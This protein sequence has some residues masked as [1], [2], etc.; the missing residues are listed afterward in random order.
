MKHLI[1]LLLNLAAITAVL[2]NRHEMLTLS[3]SDHSLVRYTNDS[4]IVQCRSSTAESQLVWRSPKGEIIKEH[5]GRIHIV[6][7]APEQLKIVFLHIS[8]ADKGK[9]RCED[10][11]GDR[12]EKSFELIVYQKIAFT[13]NSTILTVKEGKDAFIRC[14][15]KGEPQPN[16]TWHY[17]GQP[18]IVESYTGNTTKF[19]I[20]ADGLQ[21]RKVTQNDTG[22][23][24]C[25]AYQ[26]NTIASDMQD[27]TILM[28]IEHKPIWRYS[29]HIPEQYVYPNG[30]VTIACE[31]IA[32]PPANFTWY[33]NGNKKRLHTDNRYTIEKDYYASTLTIRART[34]DVFDSYRCLAENQLGAIERST[35]LSR[36]VKP[37]PPSVLQLRGFNSNTFDVDV[38]S[39]RISPA[40]TP[41]TDQLMEVNGFR[42]EYMTEY[43]FKSDGGKWSNAKRRDFPF[44][45]GATFLINNLEANTTYLMRAATKN[46]AGLSDYTKV[47][48]FT[49]LSNEPKSS[50]ARLEHLNATQLLCISLVALLLCKELSFGFQ[51]VSSI[52]KLRRAVAGRW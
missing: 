44:E 50:S 41:P 14:E 6:Q 40:R 34:D 42:I 33:K 49:T 15:V 7:S 36:G 32:E 22:E 45:D 23:Y 24:T 1:G 52:T 29:K 16:V 18:I 4:L 20:L 26:V 37:P 3:P 17:N 19:Q 51:P 13:E 21:V 11:N 47:E 38:G 39:V 30:S 27:R 28:K 2:G 48:K 43:E 9:W 31:A 8:L 5:K 12:A 35:K 10:A 46:L 25:S